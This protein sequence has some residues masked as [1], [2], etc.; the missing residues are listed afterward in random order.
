MLQPG[1][2]LKLTWKKKDLAGTNEPERREEINPV[3]CYDK[4]EYSG[5]KGE[6]SLEITKGSNAE[7][8]CKRDQ[9][10]PPEDSNAEAKS[11]GEELKY[12]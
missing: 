12:G 11:D 9:Q 5:T 1:S 2:N 8:E 7:P 10:E 4:G 6:D 3:D